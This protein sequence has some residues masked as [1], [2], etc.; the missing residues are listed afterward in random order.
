MN[1]GEKTSGTYDI[2]D[3]KKE[4]NVNACDGKPVSARDG[5]FGIFECG[6]TSDNQRTNEP[7]Q[8]WILSG[9]YQ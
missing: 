5:S 4:E 7:E 9:K 3:N 2:K 8:Y 6:K 1:K